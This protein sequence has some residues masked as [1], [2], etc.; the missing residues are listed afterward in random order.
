MYKKTQNIIKKI[1]CI[2][3]RD[4]LI[5]YLLFSFIICSIVGLSMA[6]IEHPF[7]MSILR[8]F[9]KL[10]FKFLINILLLYFL[11]VALLPFFN[12]FITTIIIGS[13]G[14]IIEIISYYKIQYRGTPLL[15]WDIF[16]VNDALNIVP[17]LSL[18]L[19]FI[20]IFSLIL[21]VIAV[22]LSF[23]RKPFKLKNKKFKLLKKIG[24]SFF[25]LIILSLISTSIYLF[26]S[27][28]NHDDL[29]N[30][31][32]YIRDNGFLFS[33]IHY[34]KYLSIEK[35]DGYSENAMNKCLEYLNNVNNINNYKNTINPDIIIIMSESFWNPE[36]LNGIKFEEEIIPNFKNLSEQNIKGEILSPVFGGGT[37]DVEYEMLTGF[38]YDMYPEGTS[39]YMQYIKDDFFSI[40]DFLENKGY[41]TLAIHSE[42]EKNWNRNNVYKY[43]EFD[44]FISLEDMENPEMT[45]GRVSDRE[46]TRYIIDNY[47]KHIAESDAPLFNFIIT[48]QNHTGY[49]RNKFSEDELVKFTSENP[50]SPDAEGQL[51]DF[52]TGVHISDEELGKLADYFMNQERPVLLIFFGDHRVNLGTENREIY[53]ATNTINDDMTEAEKQYTIHTTPIMAIS[54]FSDTHEDLN[55]MAPYMILPSVFEAYGL[56]TPLY[57][58]FLNL[59]REKS[60]GAHLNM[61]LDSEGVPM[62]NVPEDVE[63]LYKVLNMVQYDYIIGENYIGDEIFK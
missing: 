58:D 38:S 51:A 16:L 10:P 46:I 28:N 14:Y 39:P 17:S 45:R 52:S 12:F 15:P 32:G 26:S 29:W 41:S 43:M 22:I 19:N 57:F 50:L 20:N 30:P 3:N 40:V 56:D 62:E 37:A 44:D 6:L 33:F 5:S 31:H 11:Y 60:T 27:G 42:Q 23:K 2:L 61:T 13:F 7:L 36:S 35:P 18:K 55:V 63:T 59:I 53:Y 21:I 54:N 34:A 25:S 4:T 48:M 24:I 9:I 47:E 49:D 8:Y 1:A